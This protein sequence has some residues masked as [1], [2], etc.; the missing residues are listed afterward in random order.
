MLG[1]GLDRLIKRLQNGQK[2]CTAGISVDCLKLAERK[3]FV[4]NICIK[5]SNMKKRVY[6][7]NYNKKMKQHVKDVYS[8]VK[9]T[10][11]DDDDSESDLQVMEL[12]DDDESDLLSDDAYED[13]FKMSEEQ[14]E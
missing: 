5:C 6:H 2:L 13:V 14:D 10:T 3:D 1:S 11:K 9:L 12:S 7:Q 4:G 8:G